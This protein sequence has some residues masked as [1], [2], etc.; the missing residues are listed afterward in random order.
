[1]P[2]SDGPYEVV[3]DRAATADLSAIFDY[4]EDRAGSTIATNFV[5][6]LYAFCCRLEHTPERGTKRDEVRAGLRSIGYRRRATILFEVDHRRRRVIIVGVYYGGRNY[7]T[8][9]D[10]ENN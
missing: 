2:R 10:D 1:M 3:F 9:F 7:E 6:R 8:D 4:I 5:N